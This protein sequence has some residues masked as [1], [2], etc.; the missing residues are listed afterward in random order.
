MPSQLNFRP[1]VGIMLANKQKKVWI[2]ERINMPNAWQMPQ[3][4]IETNE[5]PKNAA[6]RELFEETGIRPDDITLIAESTN[7]LTFIWPEELQKTLWNGLYAGQQLKWFLFELKTNHD[8]TNLDVSH[9]EFKLHSWVNVNELPPL[10]VNF[11]RDMYCTIINEFS[12]YF[13]D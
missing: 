9:P 1:C 7:W 4:G 13:D 12:W 11:K 5:D 8:T 10:I 2:G 3:G 6:Y